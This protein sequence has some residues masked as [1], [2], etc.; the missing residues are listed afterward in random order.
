MAQET[1]AF[2]SAEGPV[3]LLQ[4][5]PELV[6]I[7]ESHSTIALRG[8]PKD[9]AH[10][11]AGN[12]TF[13]LRS[14]QTSNTT[15]LVAPV[16]GHDV[17]DTLFA[18]SD[19]T[20]ARYGTLLLTSSYI[21]VLPTA[22]KVARVK[23]LLEQVPYRGPDEE[24]EEA[25]G[26]SIAELQNRVQA[27]DGEIEQVLRD[28]DAIA[29]E[30]RWRVLDPEYMQAVV[31]MIIDSAVADGLDLES[32]DLDQAV[33]ASLDSGYPDEV[34][35]H[36]FRNFF[37]RIEGGAWS[38]DVRKLTKFTGLHLLGQKNRMEKDEFLR[39]WGQK[40]GV[41]QPSL[42]LLKGFVLVDEVHPRQAEQMITFF[43]KTDLSLDPATR[44]RQLF[45]RRQRW[46]ES[47][48]VPFVEDLAPTKKALDALLLKFA[49][50]SSAGGVRV[51]TPRFT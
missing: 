20:D 3:H 1:V 16:R 28:M 9:E 48:F 49:R 47:E 37:Q 12:A 33:S 27:S 31:A 38:L 35:E 50:V 13:L 43:P 8:D 14:V 42:D 39:L 17:A 41:E 5:P 36:V 46:S 2:R 15:I 44:F 18:P 4:L 51:V 25:V 19:E 32:L 10:L 24:L 11:V 21:E 30:G 34:L 6:D 7:I 26:Y 40:P 23:T 29:I 45:D 22:P